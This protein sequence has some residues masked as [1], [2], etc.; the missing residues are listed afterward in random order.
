MTTIAANRVAVNPYDSPR[1][2]CD[3]A[4]VSADLTVGEAGWSVDYELTP[5]DLTGWSLYVAGNSR[6]MKKQT[7]AL[8]VM[9]TIASILP[10]FWIEA[11]LF[12]LRM[13]GESLMLLQMAV[14][15]S[16]LAAVVGLVAVCLRR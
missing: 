16:L 15:G 11:L 12:M 13:R 14:H 8:R 7:R 6:P 2:E 3:L 4:Q 1:A 10:L 9:I 5:A